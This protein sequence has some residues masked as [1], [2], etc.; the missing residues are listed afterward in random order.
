MKR[1]T[2]LVRL[3]ALVVLLFGLFLLLQTGG[4]RV[5]SYAEC[6]EAGYPVLESF[7]AKCITPEGGQFVQPVGNAHP[8]LIQ[9]TTPTEGA[10]I[11]SPVNITGSARGYWYFEASFPVSV[12]DDQGTLLGQGIATA[13]GEWMTEEFVPF[14]GSIAFTKPKTKTGHV[15]FKN[16]NPSGEAERDKEVRI[17]V[18]FAEPS[19]AAFGKEIQLSIGESVQLPEDVLLTLVSIDDSRCKPDV[20]CVWAGELAPVFSMQRSGTTPIPAAELRLCTSDLSRLA[21]YGEYMMQLTAA[22]ESYAAVVVRHN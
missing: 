7:P 19:A 5:T 2:V 12:V 10:R 8:D 14:T 18:T 11:Q 21:T 3:G 22:T 20:Q 1:T 9:V 4:P 6:I 16:D 13:D 17:N 15:V